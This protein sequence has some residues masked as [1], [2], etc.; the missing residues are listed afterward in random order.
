VKPG[1]PVVDG[2]DLY[3]EWLGDVVLEHFEVSI[4]LQLI[5]IFLATSK[6]VVE[7]DHVVTVIQQSLQSE[8]PIKP[9]PPVTRIR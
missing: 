9:A 5:K 2:I 1:R 8:V 3:V 4:Q 7:T 6:E